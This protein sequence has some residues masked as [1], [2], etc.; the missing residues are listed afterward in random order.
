[1]VTGAVSYRRGF[2]NWPGGP[3][4][5]LTVGGHGGWFVPCRTVCWCAGQGPPLR[6]SIGPDGM[7]SIR[8]RWRREISE[9][10]WDGQRLVFVKG[11]RS[12]LE[13]RGMQKHCLAKVVQLQKKKTTQKEVGGGWQKVWFCFCFFVYKKLSQ[14]MW[15]NAKLTLQRHL[16]YKL[17]KRTQY[18]CMQLQQ[19]GNEHTRSSFWK[20]KTLLRQY[21][22]GFQTKDTH[23]FKK[24]QLQL[25]Y[26]CH[27]SISKS[28][29][30]LF[31]S[32]WTF[33]LIT[34]TS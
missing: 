8:R 5:P 28:H 33:N 32:V 19:L 13:G 24:L 15:N 11:T 12:S 10:G 27:S 9:R 25:I 21:W 26:S 34:Q 20:E 14:W 16:L 22:I 31:S 29:K 2:W 23:H 3:K 18:N 30:C 6:P 1:M 7:R 4:I 17:E